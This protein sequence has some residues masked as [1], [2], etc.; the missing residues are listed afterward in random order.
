[1]VLTA[2]DCQH[3]PAAVHHQL[4]P[5]DDQEDAKT[6]DIDRQIGELASLYAAQQERLYFLGHL[7]PLYQHQLHLLSQLPLHPLLCLLLLQKKHK[8]INSRSL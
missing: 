5:H 6:R 1:M 3:H 8:L 2:D 7:P 4:A